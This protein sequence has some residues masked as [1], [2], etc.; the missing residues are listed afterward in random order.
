MIIYLY[1]C[2]AL[3]FI[4]LIFSQN[5]ILF[6]FDP[7]ENNQYL[8]SSYNTN[9]LDT[10]NYRSIVF[11]QSHHI[12]FG[13]YIIKD[14]KNLQ[15]ADSASVLSQLIL[16][17]DGSD[18]KFRDLLISLYSRN[19]NNVSFRYAGHTR[20]YTP[21]YYIS[22]INQ[23][24]ETFLQNHM[25]DIYKESEKSKFNSIIMYHDENP[26]VPISYYSESNEGE[27]DFYY[28]TR[29]SKSF[30]WGAMYDLDIND[31]LSISLKNSNHYS[32]YIQYINR[33][34]TDEASINF[35]NSY[36]TIFNDISLAYRIKKIKW[37][38]KYFYKSSN[39][40]SNQHA[41]FTSDH[42]GATTEFIFKR[43]KLDLSVGGSFSRIYVPN[44]LSIRMS[45]YDDGAE[46]EDSQ[47]ESHLTSDISNNAK[48]YVNP[49]IK[50]K[51]S[52]NSSLSILFNMED[53]I[54]IYENNY[55]GEY[56]R[57]NVKF[58]HTSLDVIHKYKNNTINF[59]IGDQGLEVSYIGL[60]FKHSSSFFNI[61][62]ESK[63]FLGATPFT[64]S[65][66]FFGVMD[67]YI[68]Y[69]LTFIYP[70]ANRGFTAKI[71]ITGRRIDMN[72]G[73]YVVDYPLQREI[74]ESDFFG[75]PSYYYK[76]FG[77]LSLVL[78]FDKFVISYHNITNNRAGFSVPYPYSDMG[79]A[80]Q[81]ESYNFLGNSFPAF[82]YLRVSWTFID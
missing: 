66:E 31:N 82:Q 11:D 62:L 8:L 24:G 81:L 44:D 75:P 18:Y 41:N 14:L 73:V 1:R 59:I 46:T 72:G 43:D 58:L 39:V 61:F 74:T 26:K 37:V 53:K 38:S 17:R 68:K 52:L 13:G 3:T 49:K 30:L 64:G 76:N 21:L 6:D 70:F 28:I 60:N 51:Y 69:G 56:F 77:D 2:I 16:K 54:G 33:E 35:D 12:P 32:Y 5:H 10:L 80:F 20:S 42:H 25:I 22:D 40:Y 67:A 57:N 34:T 9:I 7:V 78:E 55:D 27:G 23:S 15:E 50:I 47:D 19:D 29:D 45:M 4:T 71:N 65:Q 79:T 48:S 36:M 63:K